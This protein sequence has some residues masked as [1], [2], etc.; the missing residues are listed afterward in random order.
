VQFDDS[1]MH[2]EQQDA[3]IQTVSYRPYAV[4]VDFAAVCQC[5]SECIF[6]F[7]VKYWH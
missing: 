5:S 7:R 1:S 3:L 2:V 6:F 4:P